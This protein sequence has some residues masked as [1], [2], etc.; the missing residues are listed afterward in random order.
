LALVLF[1]HLVKYMKFDIHLGKGQIGLK[2]KV[3][4][5]MYLVVYVL[6]S[7]I[8]TSLIVSK[9]FYM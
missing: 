2:K 3:Y 7:V 1:L 5:F 8:N 9:Y 6:F 4:Y